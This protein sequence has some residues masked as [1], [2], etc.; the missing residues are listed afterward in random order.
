MRRIDAPL[1]EYTRFAVGGPADLLIDCQSPEEFIEEL[2]AVRDEHLV[3]GGGTNL[4]VA[5]EGYR[6][7]V[8][9]LVGKGIEETGEGLI[10]EGGADLEAVVRHAVG[11]GLAGVESL[12]RIPGWVSGAVYGNAG[13]YGQ[14]I[15][16]AV[17]RVEIFDGQQRRWLTNA[18]C[19]FTYR[20]SAFKRNKHW[21]ILRA[22]FALRPGDAAALAAHAEEIRA[23]RDAKFPVTMRCAGSIFKNLFFANLPEAVKPRVPPSLIRE[24]K[25]PSAF[26]LEQVGA[27]G[28]RRG[29]IEVAAYHANL[30][31][32]RGDGRAADVIR[33]IDELNARMEREFGFRLE[34]EVQ[35]VG[36]PNRISH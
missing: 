25:V 16:E 2:R 36:F 12:M 3:L 18:E 13:A 24:G 29:E 20:S 1:S 7:T 15:H 4:I 21:R 31:Y 22:E 17:T 19:G 33:L 8:L 6:G 14:S 34:E 27:K 11:G 35:F 23:T 10:V 26:F 5:D 30:I 9:R 32:N 28:E